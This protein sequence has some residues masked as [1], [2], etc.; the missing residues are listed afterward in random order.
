[1]NNTFS[2]S[3]L[4]QNH[5]QKYREVSSFLYHEISSFLHREIT[6]FIHILFLYWPST[7][8]PSGQGFAKA[9]P[10]DLETLLA[11]QRQI[12]D[13]I[14]RVRAQEEGDNSIIRS[15]NHPSSP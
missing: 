3:F 11:I 12:E 1:M 13:M 6:F 8:D 10:G 9:V 7:M 15:S 2:I 4:F 14:A 5:P